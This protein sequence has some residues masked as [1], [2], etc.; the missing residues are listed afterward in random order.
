[1]ARIHPGE[2]NSSFIMQGL[3]EYLTG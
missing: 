2:S 1:M 3:I